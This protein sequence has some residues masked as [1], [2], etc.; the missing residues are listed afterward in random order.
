MVRLRETLKHWLLFVL[1][2]KSWREFYINFY[3]NFD[4]IQILLG[5]RSLSGSTLFSF[6]S[7]ALHY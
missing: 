2:F 5:L 1:S 6:L 7:I 4:S 3:I